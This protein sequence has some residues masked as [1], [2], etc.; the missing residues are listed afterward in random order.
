MQ[1]KTHFPDLFHVSGSKVLKL[2]DQHNYYF[3]KVIG[4][5]CPIF[6]GHL[7]LRQQH[8]TVPCSGVTHKIEAVVIVN[9]IHLSRRNSSL[10]TRGFLCFCAFKGSETHL[11]IGHFNKLLCIH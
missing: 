3:H 4:N 11:Y 10:L 8:L 6:L 5:G 1:R 7:T 9:I 2:V